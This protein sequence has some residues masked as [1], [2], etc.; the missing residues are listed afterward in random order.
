METTLKIIDDTV[1]YDDYDV[2]TTKALGGTELVY[3]WMTSRLP[4]GLIDDV[5]IICQ[6]VRELEDKPKILWLHD[7]ADDPESQHLKD[8]KNLNKFDTLVYCSYW[9]QQQ[10]VTK[11]GIPHDSGIVIQH[12][13]DPVPI[14]D[15]PD[16]NEKIKLIYASTP[17]RGLDVLLAVFQKLLEERDDIELD[18]YSS[19]KLYDRPEMD[20]QFQ[21]LYQ[22]AQETKNVNY[23]GTVS[24]DEV[25][26]AMMNSHILAYPCCYEET[27][28]ITLI[29]AM[30]AGLLCVVPGFGALPETAA[31]FAYMYNF[32]LDKQR[33][34]NV[35]YSVLKGALDAYKDDNVRTMLKTQKSYYDIFY[36]WETRI[37]KWIQLIKTI[38]S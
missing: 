12:A 31:N 17:H 38:T 33:H 29:E 4:E 30:S 25:R 34:A 8:P 10:F 6:R 21:E 13:I 36:S 37:P 11:L 20:K 5:Q 9:Q 16:H 1:P 35:F 32:T 26:K 27:S 22:A 3:N 15:K 19:F 2:K 7:T 18:I 23:H 14:H 28:C 24:N